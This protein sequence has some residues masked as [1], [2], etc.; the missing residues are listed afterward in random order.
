MTAAELPSLDTPALLIDL[1]IV[2]RNLAFM[3]EKADT[4]GAA[5]RPHIKTHKIPELA[6]MQVSMGASG[7]TDEYC[8]MRHMNN[9]ESVYT[10]EGTHEMHTLIIA[11]AL[12][13]HAAYR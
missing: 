4:H 5:L 13:G 11:E 12:T 10:Y 2:A 9:L 7:I 6:R 3:Q 8:S 1:D